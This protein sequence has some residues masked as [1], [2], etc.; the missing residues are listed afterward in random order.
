[1]LRLKI[2]LAVLGA[3]DDLV[4][5]KQLPNLDLTTPKPCALVV[6]DTLVDCDGS[7]YQNIHAQYLT[8]FL[9]KIA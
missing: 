4:C 3:H 1:M 6:N 5:A 9:A 8:P 7:A 2:L